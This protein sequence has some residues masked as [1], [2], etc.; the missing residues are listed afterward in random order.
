MRGTE[1][2]SDAT[3]KPQP[4]LYAST[5]IAAPEKK[6]NSNYGVAGATVV[7]STRVGV[8]RPVFAREHLS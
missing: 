1:K 8:T 7:D 4:H 5:S 3:Q 2:A 6:K